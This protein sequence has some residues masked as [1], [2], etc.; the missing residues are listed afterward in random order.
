MKPFHL[1]VRASE[2]A[3]E[4]KR[5]L[6]PVDQEGKIRMRW[7]RDGCPTIMREVRDIM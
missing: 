6:L 4:V 5:W 1:G 7:R 2:L 3:G